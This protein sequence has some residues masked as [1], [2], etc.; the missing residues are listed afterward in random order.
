MGERDKRERER[1][2][3]RDGGRCFFNYFKLRRKKM[4]P[5]KCQSDKKRVTAEERRRES[6]FLPVLV[7]RE[8]KKEE[9]KIGGKGEMVSLT[10]RSAE[11]YKNKIFAIWFTQQRARKKWKR[12]KKTA[13]NSKERGGCLLIWMNDRQVRCSQRGKRWARE[14]EEEYK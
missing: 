5:E 6:F 3:E 13:T 8:E 1:E 9:G 14:R 4:G 12:R 7:S 11:H 2:R 10:A